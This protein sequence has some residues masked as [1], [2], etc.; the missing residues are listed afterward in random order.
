VDYLWAQTLAGWNSS[1]PP[2][3]V[4]DNLGRWQPDPARWPSSANG[5][6]FKAVA[7]HVHGRNLRF[8]IHIMRGISENA[9]KANLPIPGAPAGATTATIADFTRPCPWYAPMLAVNMSAPGAQTWMNSLY[10]Q[11][12]EWGVDFIKNDCTFGGNYA[13]DNINAVSAAMKAAGGDWVYSLS[14]GTV[15]PEEVPNAKAI[16]DDVTMY[17]V[18]G[19]DWDHSSDVLHHFAAAALF[20][21]LIGA[22]GRDAKPSFPDL[23]MLPFGKIA[24][25]C[26]NRENGPKCTP[27]HQTDLTPGQ[28]RMQM[29]LWAM[30]RSPLFFGGEVTALD[31]ATLAILTNEAILSINGDSKNNSCIQSC[32]T[33][34]SPAGPVV[35]AA[36]SASD[37]PGELTLYAALFNAADTAGP[38]SVSVPEIGGPANKVCTYQEHWGGGSG[39]TTQSGVIT[40]TVAANDVALYSIN[41]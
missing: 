26:G 23:D 22:P 30:A 28:Q 21:G 5:A 33:S 11:Y 27:N 34:A 6:G 4:I 18:A 38:V 29:T 14:P 13:A 16:L 24:T 7:D 35:W 3:L 25:P 40:A 10:S 31:D 32:S 1:S 8:G 36:Q 9:V 12:K 2:D 20:Q 17:R 15:A 37:K 39:S 41:C 19:D